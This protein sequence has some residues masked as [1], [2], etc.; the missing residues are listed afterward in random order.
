MVVWNPPGGAACFIAEAALIATS[1]GLYAAAYDPDPDYRQTVKLRT[2]DIGSFRE[3]EGLD[4]R[5]SLYKGAQAALEAAANTRGLLEAY[6]RYLGAVEAE[7]PKWAQ[8]QAKAAGGFA[9]EAAKQVKKCRELMQT[10]AETIENAKPDE[11]ERAMAQAKT[12][13][14]PALE[15]QVLGDLGFSDKDI[16]EMATP[17]PEGLDALL[18]DP[19]LA[20]AMPDRLGKALDAFAREMARAAK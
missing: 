2:V 17:Y 9:R 12:G 6:A 3:L 5:D 4:K 13:E 19:K 18:K 16:A 15:K 1:H 7:D 11:L 10:A 8:A 20:A 14:L